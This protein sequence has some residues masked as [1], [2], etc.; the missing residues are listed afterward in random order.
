[1]LLVLVVLFIAVPVLEI[2]IL[3]KLGAILGLWPTVAL[4]VGTGLVGAW[5]ARMEGWR[6]WSRLHQEI[7]A[8]RVPAESMLDGLLI[9]LG[10]VL[11][12][13]PGVL[14]DVAG[15]VVLIPWTRWLVKRWL[16]RQFERAIREGRGSMTLLIR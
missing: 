1:M 8:G 6:V 14:T 12:L 9:F 2:A 15:L 7:A 13:A 5:L 11:L 4:V 10:G 16:R 3:V